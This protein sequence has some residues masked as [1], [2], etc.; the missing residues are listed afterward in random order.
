LVHGRIVLRR[1]PGVGCE[2]TDKPCVG[3]GPAQRGDVAIGEVWVG[4][5][6]RFHPD[7]ERFGRVSGVGHCAGCCLTDGLDDLE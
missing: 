3:D 2:P 5:R 4:G 6:L 1:N 7:P